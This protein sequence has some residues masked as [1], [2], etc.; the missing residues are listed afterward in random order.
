MTGNM[1]LLGVAGGRGEGTLAL[2]AGVAFVGY[3]LGT[4]GGARIAG[5]AVPGEAI[6]PRSTSHALSAELVILVL[7]SV[8]WELAR[9]DPTSGEALGLLGANAVALGVQSS[10]VL[11]FG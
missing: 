4:V 1:V 2:H 3:I 11:R 10:A 6:W 9:G 8:G 5:R 7:F